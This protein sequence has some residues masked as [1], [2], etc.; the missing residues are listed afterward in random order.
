MEE[1][2]E[3]GVLHIAA[4]TRNYSVRSCSEGHTFY[5]ECVRRW[6]LKSP[7]CPLDREP[8]RTRMLNKLRSL[9]NIISQLKVF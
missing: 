9:E 8:L 7:T 6:M 4:M 5:V 3:V 2:V 1:K